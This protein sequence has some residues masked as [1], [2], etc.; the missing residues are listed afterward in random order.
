MST[1][2]EERLPLVLRSKA[3]DGNVAEN[4][5]SD[6]VVHG[7]K[8]EKFCVFFFLIVEKKT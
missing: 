3:L 4:T 1:N 7:I 5:E 2:H 6:E 8:V